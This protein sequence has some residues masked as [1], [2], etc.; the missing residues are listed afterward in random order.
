M[1]DA[2]RN[3]KLTTLIRTMTQSASDMG[4]SRSKAVQTWGNSVLGWVRQLE[5]L[6]DDP[7]NIQADPIYEPGPKWKNRPGSNVFTEEIDRHL[8]DTEGLYRNFEALGPTLGF[9][10]SALQ[11]RYLAIKNFA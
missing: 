5:E 7:K 4:A 11:K 6:V 3:K 9:T 10:P 1:N 2:Q 8:I